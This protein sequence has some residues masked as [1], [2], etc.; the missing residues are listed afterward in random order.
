MEIKGDKKGNKRRCEMRTKKILS[1]VLV[2]VLLVLASVVTMAVTPVAA[3]S[4][5]YEEKI[6]G[7]ADEN[8]ELTKEELVNAI[9]PYMLEEGDLKLDDVGDAAHVYVYWD[10]EPRTF[11]D[12]YD[13][14]VTF[15]R[16][17]ERI[18]ATSPNNIKMVI[19]L[20]SD[21]LVA[22]T[23]NGIRSVC[24]P[25]GGTG[26]SKTTLCAKVCGGRYFELP[27]VGKGSIDS[28]EVVISVEPDL[29]IDSSRTADATQDKTGIPTVAIRSSGHNLDMVYKEIE[30]MG[31]LF[32][33]EGEAEEL[34][35]FVNDK[36]DKLEEVTSQIPEE[37]KPKVYFAT[38]GYS[39]RWGGIS[40]TVN[41]Y[42]PINI[43]G[44][45]NVAKDILPETGGG[46]SVLVSKEYIIKWNP[47]IILI[48]SGST[49]GE[50]AIETMLL[51]PELQTVN[52]IKNESVYYTIYPYSHGTPQ[53]RNLVAAFY[54]AKLFHQDKFEDLDVEKEGNEI[55]EA[56]LGVDGLFSE[57]A[58]GRSWMREFLDEQQKS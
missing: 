52:A 21:N 56:F 14:T 57:Y 38:R 51:E 10:G 2:M 44:G 9:L 4:E 6:A 49:T 23:S 19:A 58:D 24:Q 16:P 54:L 17:I 32:E 39:T 48:A 12:S 35:S 13:R 28:L 33:K 45:I 15:Y 20:A 26:G 1:I 11:K 36:A 37:K 55:Y 27:V 40:K 7:D 29:I 3:V 47:D 43:A 41:Y 50:T 46:T 22:L 18:V 30:V 53:D 31:M 42:D 34:I 8:N 25:H 5:V